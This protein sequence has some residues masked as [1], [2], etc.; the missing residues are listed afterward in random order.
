M[1][2]RYETRQS[3]FLFYFRLFSFT[4][5]PFIHVFRLSNTDIT[6]RKNQAS[7]IGPHDITRF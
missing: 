3:Q 5:F 6:S 7:I 2:R 4:N 1:K